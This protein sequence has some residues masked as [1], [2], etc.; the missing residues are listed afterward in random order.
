MGEWVKIKQGAI[1]K[2]KKPKNINTYLNK[3]FTIT[4]SYNKGG[5]TKIQSYSPLT[6]LEAWEQHKKRGVGLF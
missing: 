2:I 3:G 4:H 6:K 5:V 1:Y